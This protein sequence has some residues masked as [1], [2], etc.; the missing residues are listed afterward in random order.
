MRMREPIM[1]FMERLAVTS[2]DRDG[3]KH[4]LVLM[5]FYSRCLLEQVDFNTWN[6]L[7]PADMNINEYKRKL[8]FPTK[9]LYRECAR[10]LSDLTD[11][12]DNS[13]HHRYYS[14]Q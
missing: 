1:K 4:H 12:K 2:Y 7:Q 13:P 11:I 9:V 14:I 6:I 5:K 3:R 8:T 10:L